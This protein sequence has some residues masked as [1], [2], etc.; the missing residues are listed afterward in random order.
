MDKE[1]ICIVCP[2]GCHLRVDDEL[3][4]SGNFCPRGATYAK[5][6]LT[7]PERTL[8]TTVRIEGSFLPLVPVKT[9]SP[10]PKA[11]IGKAMAEIGK[12]SLKAP[13]KCGDLVI[14]NILGT[15]VD[16]V[17]TRNMEKV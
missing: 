7:A 12:V 1:L 9:K 2:R 13:V 5:K 3:N 14:E 6:E 8:T 17:V 16:V 15:N 4:V 10:I 11:L